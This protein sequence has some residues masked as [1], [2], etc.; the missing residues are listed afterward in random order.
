MDYTSLKSSFWNIN[1]SINFCL[2][3]LVVLLLVLVLVIADEADKQ[4]LFG[5][6]VPSSGLLE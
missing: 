6:R 4:D 1:S 3:Q 5:E 2:I